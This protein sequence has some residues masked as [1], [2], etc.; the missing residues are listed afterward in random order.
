MRRLVIV[1][2]LLAISGTA[3]AMALGDIKIIAELTKL[4]ETMN[5]QL[6]TLKSQ[7]ENI[8]T[9]KTLYKDSVETYDTV[10]NFR[11]EDIER[12]IE[13]DF[14][15]LTGLD[16]MDGLSLRQRLRVIDRELDRRVDNAPPASRASVAATVKQQRDLLSRYET[17]IALQE[18]IE[19]NLATSRQDIDERTAGQIQAQNASILSLLKVLEAKA[20]INKD[21]AQVQDQGRL[22][23]MQSERNGVYGAIGQTGW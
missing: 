15:N 7:N 1:M 3:Q 19:A 21:L 8:Q 22:K 18:A 6:Q 16:N 17:M 10:V 12:R 14:D 5:Q 20:Q 9:L 23:Q 11:L 2:V 4:Y 13:R